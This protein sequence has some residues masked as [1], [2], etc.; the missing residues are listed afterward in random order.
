[1]EGHRSSSD[2]GG[3]EDSILGFDAS[4]EETVLVSLCLTQARL[5]QEHRGSSA[6]CLNSFKAIH[7]AD[8]LLDKIC[9]VLIL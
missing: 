4:A 1:M 6:V 7:Q 9:S 8:K 2:K 5:G 3:E